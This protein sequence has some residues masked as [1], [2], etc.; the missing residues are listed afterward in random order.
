MHIWISPTHS[1]S[2]SAWKLLHLSPSS[3][4]FD[5]PNSEFFCHGLGRCKFYENTTQTSAHSRWV[6]HRNLKVLRNITHLE[7]SNMVSTMCNCCKIRRTWKP[8]LLNLL[9]QSRCHLDKYRQDVEQVFKNIVSHLLKIC[10]HMHGTEG[11][12]VCWN[13]QTK[14]KKLS[15]IQP[16][17]E[18]EQDY[19]HLNDLVKHLAPLR[20]FIRL[21]ISGNANGD[22]V[23]PSISHYKGQFWYFPHYG[24]WTNLIP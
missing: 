16:Q 15:F 14:C 18:S 9:N 24:S 2:L 6:C 3:W 17:D 5:T 20:C 1:S 10:W 22:L 21:K 4:E 19:V 23:K 11:I 12:I 7:M 13:I 8:V